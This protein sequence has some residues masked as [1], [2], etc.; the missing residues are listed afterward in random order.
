MLKEHSH[1][2]PLNDILLAILTDQCLAQ[3]SS[4][5]PSP[6]TDS[7]KYRHP[8]LDHVQKVRGIGTLY[9]E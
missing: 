3:L 4:G 5:I 8:Q 1:K 7:N 6:A 9:P 2:V